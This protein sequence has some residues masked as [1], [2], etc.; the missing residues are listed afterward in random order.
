MCRSDPCPA[1]PQT[2][3]SRYPT[4]LFRLKKAIVDQVMK[5]LLSPEFVKQLTLEAVKYREV[6]QVDPTQNQC[7]DTAKLEAC[8]SK[9]MEMASE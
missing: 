1:P 3:P 2:P 5:D 8:I 6:H 9:K 4:D 7:A